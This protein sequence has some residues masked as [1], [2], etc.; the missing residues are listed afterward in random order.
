MYISLSE[1]RAKGFKRWSE[2]R[3]PHSNDDADGLVRFDALAVAATGSGCAAAATP[4][5]RR[6]GS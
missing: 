6:C 3:Q 4:E 2:T 5:S 1:S